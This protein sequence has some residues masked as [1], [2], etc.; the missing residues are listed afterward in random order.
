MK[1]RVNPQPATLNSRSVIFDMDGAL[2]RVEIDIEEVRLALAALF[3]PYGI[4]RPFRPILARIGQAA[5]EAKAKGGDP[6]EL[7]KKGL[8][9]LDVWEQRGAA[10]ARARA[11]APEVIAELRQRGTPLGLLTNCGRACVVPALRA[12]GLDPSLFEEIVTRDEAAPKPDPEGLVRLAAHL[13][14]D[15]IW[16]VVDHAI[17]LDTA[18]AARPNVPALR[19]ATLPGPS[20]ADVTITELRDV[21]ALG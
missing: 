14:G 7:R 20:G 16:Y 8:A 3:A 5:E 9:I 13:G 17:D 19:V 21:L 11:G 6:E 18:R 12:S 4:T 10:Q 15:P 2:L 1:L